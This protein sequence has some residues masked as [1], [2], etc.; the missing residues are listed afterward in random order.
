MLCWAVAQK[1]TSP[2]IMRK[3]GGISIFENKCFILI[4]KVHYHEAFLGVSR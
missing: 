3:I 4:R 2:K 1:E